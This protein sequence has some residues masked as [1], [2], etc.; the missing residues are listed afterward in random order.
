[1]TDEDIRD[2]WS[3]VDIKEPS[4]CW[5]WKLA[6][7]LK[8]YGRSKLLN[9]DGGTASRVALALVS[10]E[11][12][13]G[14]FA[15]H[16]CDNPPCCNPGHLRWGDFQDNADDA[17]NRDRHYRWSGQRAGSNNP[18]ARL[19]ADQVISIRNDARSASALA[20]VY[21]VSPT[22]IQG[23]KSRRTWKAIA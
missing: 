1:M 16:S 13:S 11:I 19:N 20:S 6:L 7:D 8:G 3:N 23:I 10:E 21:K 15:L 2:F 12:P 9:K 5:P 17:R 14:L 18:R 4:A 22:T